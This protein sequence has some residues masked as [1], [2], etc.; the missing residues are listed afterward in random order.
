[1]F[2]LNPFQFATDASC[3]LQSFPKS[4]M[5]LPLQEPPSCRVSEGASHSHVWVHEQRQGDP[6][7]PVT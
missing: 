6:E 3:Y 2:V 7:K 4:L 1:M 5:K